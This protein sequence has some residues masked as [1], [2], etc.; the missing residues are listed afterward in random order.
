MTKTRVSKSSS[1]D[2]L[3]PLRANGFSGRTPNGADEDL[4]QR[5]LELTNALATAERKLVE[6][7]KRHRQVEAMCREE[8]SAERERIRTVLHDGVGQILTSVSF[9]ATALRQKLA[10]RNLPEAADAQEIVALANK[11]VAESRVLFAP[12]NRR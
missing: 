2:R 6:E 4:H 5:L 9:I 11:A 3:N 12:V 7:A 1:A 8:F 10:G